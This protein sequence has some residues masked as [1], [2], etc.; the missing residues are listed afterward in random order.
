[1]SLNER[2]EVISTPLASA[3]NGRHGSVCPVYG[4]IIAALALPAVCLAPKS[5]EQPGPGLARG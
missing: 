1:M 4:A 2:G 5:K 3:Y